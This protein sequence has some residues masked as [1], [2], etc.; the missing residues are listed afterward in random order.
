MTLKKALAI[1]LVCSFLCASV[2]QPAWA[3]GAEGMEAAPES[4]S[5]NSLGG[6]P[7][8]GGDTIGSNPLFQPLL[9]QV[10]LFSPEQ[11]D[12]IQSEPLKTRT[13]VAHPDAIL[14]QREAISSVI[15]PENF[16]KLLTTAKRLN[17]AVGEAL[18]SG[19]DSVAALQEFTKH[20]DGAGKVVAG[21]EDSV[22]SGSE[23]G[24]EILPSGLKEY[25]PRS[26]DSPFHYIEKDGKKFLELKFGK[27]VRTMEMGSGGARAP[28]VKFLRPDVLEVAVGEKPF[29]VKLTEDNLRS[30]A[31]MMEYLSDPDASLTNLML[32]GDMG[33]GKNTL[34]YTLAGLLN[35]GVR[36]MSFHAHTNEKDLRYRTTLGEE[37][38]GETSRKHS[39]LYE[40]AEAGDW[41]ILDEPNKPLQIGI[42]NS[43]NTILQNRQ[44]TLPG[45]D[46]PVVGNPKFRA[47]ALVNPPNRSYTVQEMPAD[48]IRRFNV[49]DVDYMKA[50]DETDFVMDT[51]FLDE[52][53]A[54][55]AQLRPLIEQMVGLANDLRSSYR[56]GHLPRP[57]STRGV[58]NMA[59]HIKK[60][61]KDFP[62]FREIFDTVYPTE[63]LEANEKELVDEYLKQHNLQGQPRPADFKL[64]DVEIDEKAGKVRLGNDQWGVVELPLGD[65]KSSEIP[66]SY[67]DIPHLQSNLRLWW[68]MMKDR[69]LGRHSLVLGETGTGKTQLMGHF[70][71]AILRMKPEEQTFTRQTRGQD[72]IGKPEL[73]N[74]ATYWPPYP[75]ER[76]VER[77]TIWL[78][79]EV[80][81]PEDPGTVS[82]LNNVLQFGQ[83]LLPSGKVLDAKSGFGVVAMGTPARAQYE[84][85][86]FSGEVLDRFSTHILK[87]LPAEEEM[88]LVESYARQQGLS[89][90]RPVLEAL[91]KALDS[92]RDSYRQGLLPVPPSVQSLFRVVSRLGRFPDTKDDIVQTFLSAFPAWE[93]SH[94]DIIRA[95][96]APVAQA[97]G[98]SAVTAKAEPQDHPKAAIPTTAPAG[99]TASAAPVAATP[100]MEAVSRGDTA[101]VNALIAAGENINARGMDGDT[102]LGRASENG[103]TDTVKALIAAGADINAES[104][105]GYTA[106]VNASIK[107]HTDTV[108]ALIAA[109]A[110]INA[111]SKYGNIALMNAS[112]K[113]HTDTIKALIAAGA[114][115]NAKNK[116]GNTALMNASIKSLKALIAAGADVNA[117]N[118]LGNTALMWASRDGKTDT[119]KALIAA[120]ADIN[121]ESKYGYT[122]LM[123]AS[124]NGHTDTVN[125]LIAA[126]ADV[127]AKNK[128]GNTA[129]VNASKDGKTDTVKALIAAGADVNAKNE[130]GNTA[131]MNASINGH[132]DT[133]NALIA[134]GA[135]VNAKNEL[136]NTA[137]MNASINGHTDIVKALIAAGVDVNA[138]RNYNAEKNYGDTAFLNAAISGYTGIVK[139]LIAA[140]ADINAKDNS[141]WTALMW[142]SINGHT[143]IVKALIAAGADINAKNEY[144]DTALMYALLHGRTDIVKAL[145]A[146][147]ADVNATP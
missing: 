48:F 143:D 61:P 125:A 54:K 62:Y 70:L 115:V 18:S 87:P 107:G 59:W 104:K 72:I 55:K 28:R 10:P 145:I 56:Q 96:M 53:A 81:K 36:V 130:I 131:L 94:E 58:M 144:G 78:V 41:V 30:L 26:V 27:V 71:Y 103:H 49:L 13:L 133:V 89:I 46:N 117:K 105:Y 119:V 51:V 77:N 114:D 147:G 8:G 123:N 7:I 45:E 57:L 43:L 85:Q 95:A 140:G 39:E 65:L 137:L 74:D 16:R 121:A 126:G 60:F 14:E 141:A 90:E 97:L 31:T 63:Y 19:G 122:A 111:E 50:K 35:Q 67:R 5:G 17:S 12:A 1:F 73:K 98:L 40:G 146:A 132:T 69:A 24:L 66:A 92:L 68:A 120:G 116:Y 106:L 142:A 37:R 102:A 113:G 64:P 11:L 82:L 33:T 86:E 91:Q 20:F 25:E 38:A 21:L 4:F 34:V 42:L 118:E 99:T 139:A 100:L 80:T 109:G 44:E 47:I 76:A 136:G 9:P 2:G 101:A 15:G 83:I 134:A 93:K 52:N 32:R 124:I 75:L 112:I 29:M 22:V 128:H 108:K 79:D 3:V 127:N 138:K 84:A 135:D 110:D 88:G 23:A 129:L 6:M